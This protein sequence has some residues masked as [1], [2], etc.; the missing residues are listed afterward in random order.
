MK[1]EVK[2]VYLVAMIFLGLSGCAGKPMVVE[3]V[4]SSADKTT[5]IEETTN[6]EKTNAVETSDIRTTTF[7]NTRWGDDK[8]TVKKNEIEMSW[9]S[10]DETTLRGMSEF[11]NKDMVIEFGFEN[12]KLNYVMALPDVDYADNKDLYI[13]DYNDIKE[14]LKKIYGEPMTDDPNEYWSETINRQPKDSTIWK[15]NDTWIGLGPMSWDNERW[16]QISYGDINYV[17]NVFVDSLLTGNEESTIKETTSIFIDGI[18]PEFKEAMD[19]YEVFFDEYITF[20]KKYKESSNAASMITDYTNYMTKY[21][22]T[23]NKMNA[24]A[25][26]ELSTAESAYYI[27]VTARINKKLIDA[28]Q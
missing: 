1:K 7:R 13:Q 20:M 14:T 27:E 16:L 17:N 15:S 25:D 26:G 5:V 9:M 18:R 19:S 22:D 6:P 3:T 10:E 11:L 24:L 28:I 12:E 2:Y 23:M 8:E 4:N 21:A